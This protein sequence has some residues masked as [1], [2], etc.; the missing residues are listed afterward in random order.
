MIYNFTISHINNNIK[1]NVVTH[2]IDNPSIVLIHLHGLGNHFQHIFE[3]TDSFHNRVS[4]LKPYNILSYALELSGHGLSSG[5]RFYTN[6]ISEYLSD[7]NTLIQYISLHHPLLPIH[8]MGES[9][10]GAIAIKYSMIYKNIS[11]VILLAPMCGVSL[12]SSYSSYK[13]YIMLF[14]SYIFPYSKLIDKNNNNSSYNE[15]YLEEKEKCNYTN[16]ENLRLA[17]GRECYNIMNYINNNINEFITPVIAFHSKLDETTEY[18]IT[19]NF[20][21]KCNSTNKKIILYEEGTHNLLIERN[22]NDIYPKIILETI[23]KWLCD[24]H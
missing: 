12:I 13:I 8:L 22:E 15:K 1:L 7:L 3:S 21:N 17:T 9:M 23:S 14:L 6:D 2:D 5:T 11:S 19:E 18:T 4:I 16:H 20:I 10:G 24:I